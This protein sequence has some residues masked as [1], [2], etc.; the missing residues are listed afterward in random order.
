MENEIEATLDLKR[1]RDILLD[2]MKPDLMAQ[3]SEILRTTGQEVV[4]ANHLMPF[5]DQAFAQMRTNEA[6]S[7]G[8]NGPFHCIRLDAL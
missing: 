5:L 8:D 6:S 2:E 3:R 4:H 1:P 7:S